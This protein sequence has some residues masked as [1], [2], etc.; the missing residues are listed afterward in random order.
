VFRRA[1]GHGL[2]GQIGYT[3]SQALDTLSNGGLLSFSYE[4]QRGQIDSTNLRS[5]NYSSSDYDIRHNLTADFIWETPFRFKSRLMNT[6]LGGW[7]VGNRLN[8]HTGLP[9]SVINSAIAR[10]LGL[11]ALGIPTVLAD[12]L[13]PK[14]RTTCGSSAVDTPCF[15]ANQFG[16]AR[17]QTNL[18]NLPRNSFRGPGFFD[19]DSS[20]YKTV[21]ISERM[22][23][24]FGAT[25]YNLLNHPNFADPNMDLARPGLGLIRST[26][27]GPSSPYGSYGGPSGRALVVTGK[28]K[29]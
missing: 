5:L 26:R 3:W 17:T 21:P 18:G 1:F 23:F 20:L 15:T 2:Q 8:A 16:P 9:F 13:D 7:S 12:A 24:V 27:V 19:I 28:F 11:S 22:R 6:I 14:I 29:F 25:A 4:S 10:G